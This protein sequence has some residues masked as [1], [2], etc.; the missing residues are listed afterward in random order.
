MVESLL[1]DVTNKHNNV[2]SI[3]KLEEADKA[4]QLLKIVT[5]NS[6]SD[7]RVYAYMGYIRVPLQTRVRTHRQVW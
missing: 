4:T 3:K 5:Q 7:V 1:V 2:N 6:C